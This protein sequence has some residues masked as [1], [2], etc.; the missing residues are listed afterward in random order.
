VRTFTKSVL[1]ALV[2]ASATAVAATASADIVCNADN[3]CWHV[4]RHY[5]YKPEFAVVV[6]PDNWRWGPDDHYVW[7]EHRGRGYWHSGVWVAF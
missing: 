1:A 2:A 7:K 6:H 3:I 5:D 4:H